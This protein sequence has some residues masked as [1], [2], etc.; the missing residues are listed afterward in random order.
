MT[1]DRQG[2]ELLDPVV[3]LLYIQPDIYLDLILRSWTVRHPSP[4]T[5]RYLS[6]MIRKLCSKK[7]RYIYIPAV[8]YIHN[9]HTSIMFIEPCF[10]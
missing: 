5:I 4:I 9:V 8:K 7:Y 1:Y 2:P 3:K 10:K 6:G